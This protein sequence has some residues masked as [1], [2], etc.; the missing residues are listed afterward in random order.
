MLSEAEVRFTVSKIMN[1]VG[2][3]YIITG[4]PVNDEVKP[5]AIIILND[6]RPAFVID[7]VEKIE[8][9]EADA[10]ETALILEAVEDD[11]ADY[12]FTIS[13]GQVLIINNKL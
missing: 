7:A 12:L 2:I 5:G 3:G 13:P 4:C 10:V 8:Y 11:A 1:V 6:D 9:A